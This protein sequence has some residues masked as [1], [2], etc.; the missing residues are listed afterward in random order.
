M[1][2]AIIL[3]LLTLW[4]LGG[5]LALGSLIHILL[6]FVLFFWVVRLM[7]TASSFTRSATADRVPDYL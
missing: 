4:A 2:W 1:L 5:F 3:I 7:V 6:V